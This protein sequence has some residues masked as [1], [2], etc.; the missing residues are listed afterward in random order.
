MC[1]FELLSMNQICVWFLFEFLTCVSYYN[2]HGWLGAKY[3][4]I[5]LL[6]PPACKTRVLDCDGFFM[7]V[8]FIRSPQ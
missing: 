4:V 5:Y 3:Q 6:I 1:I 2:L 7:C 8:N